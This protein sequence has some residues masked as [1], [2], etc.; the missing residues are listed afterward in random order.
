MMLPK[1]IRQLFDE[2]I[3]KLPLKK[4]YIVDGIKGYESQEDVNKLSLIQEKMSEINKSFSDLFREEKYRE[5]V[6][7]LRKEGREAIEKF[8]K[9]T[10]NLICFY[11]ETEK[12]DLKNLSLWLQIFAY[13]YISYLYPWDNTFQYFKDS[14]ISPYAFVE[15][16][17]NRLLSKYKEKVD[18]SVLKTIVSPFTKIFVIMPEGEESAEKLGIRVYDFS[19]YSELKK[20]R[21]EK[22]KDYIRYYPEEFYIQSLESESNSDKEFVRIY[23]KIK[24]NDSKDA[25]KFFYCISFLREREKQEELWELYGHKGAS[26]FLIRNKVVSQIARILEDSVYRDSVK[27]LYGDLKCREEERT[28]D[29]AYDWVDILYLLQE[30]SLIEVN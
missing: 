6:W 7:K 18:I 5:A 17:V 21:R 4:F 26:I 9:M 2:G 10:D 27:R 14:R 1:Y 3:V 22:L 19:S 12:R 30:L 13:G 28:A 15:E 23:R 20:K 8:G 29:I 25:S 24:E 16:E 11:E